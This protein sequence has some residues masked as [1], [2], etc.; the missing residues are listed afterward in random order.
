MR[1]MSGETAVSRVIDFSL[2]FASMMSRQDDRMER[3][4]DLLAVDAELARLDL[5]NVEDA[6]DQRQEMLGR[7]LDVT[8]ILLNLLGRTHRL[9]M[10]HV[11]EADDGVERRAQL[12]AHVGDE[13][14]LGLGG[15][16]GVDLGGAERNGLLLL[17]DRD[18]QVLRK[19]ADQ[20]VLLEPFLAKSTHEN[21]SSAD[22]LGGNVSM[23][24]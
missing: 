4:L 1:G 15:E 9:G 16:L 18:T 5:R 23:R 6:V 11:G 17:R 14:R 7:L 3:H 13:F 10:Q 8:R 12:M 24:G 22:Y 19:L 21:P 2:A 20:R